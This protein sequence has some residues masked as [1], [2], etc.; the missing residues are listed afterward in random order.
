[1]TVIRNIEI[2]RR[3]DVS[4]STVA[5]WIKRSIEGDEKL[6]LSRVNGKYFIKNTPDNIDLIYRLKN[7]NSRYKPKVENLVIKPNNDIYKT[8]T[9]NQLADLVYNLDTNNFIPL[10]YSYFAEGADMYFNAVEEELMNSESASTMSKIETGNYLIT[11]C[12]ELI[13]KGYKI[14]LVEVGHDYGTYCLIE[15]I[16]YL[17]ARKAFNQYISICAS[18]R[19]NQIRLQKVRTWA[20]VEG[21]SYHFDYEQD[22]IQNILLENINEENKTINLCL[23]LEYCILNSLDVEYNFSR[24]LQLVSKFNHVVIKS[25]YTKDKSH[26][27]KPKSKTLYKGSG[28]RK[29]RWDFIYSL[30]GIENYVVDDREENLPMLHQNSEYYFTSKTNFTIDFSKINYKVNFKFSEN[31][32]HFIM[33]KPSL[34]WYIKKLASQNLNYNIS[35]TSSDSIY[36]QV[37]I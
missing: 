36:I 23:F 22:S 33:K 15:L 11:I 37:N 19:M 34:D 29:K 9:S 35:K 30:L 10:K 21:I 17:K 4:P 8:F 5:N 32:Y 14:N 18:P 16:K 6:I 26:F 28:L 25:A 24:A 27:F 13:K 20:K 2:S 1:M 12:D 3:F 7:L 31:I